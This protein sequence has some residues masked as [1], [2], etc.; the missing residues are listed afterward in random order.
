MSDLIVQDAKLVDEDSIP[1]D[2]L[3][4]IETLQSIGNKL[5]AR[6]GP[7]HLSR[8]VV[9]EINDERNKTKRTE[10][11][12][13][14]QPAQPRRY[15]TLIDS[16]KRPEE[17]ALLRRVYGSLLQV[18]CVFAPE[19]V[20]RERLGGNRFKASDVD[21][22]F[23]MDE[24]EGSD[25]GQKVRDT[26]HISDFF[27][28]NDEPND[29]TLSGSV[30]RFLEI[31]FGTHVHTPTLDETAM[32]AATA[33]ARGSACLSRQV[34]AVIYGVGGEQI[35]QGC[36]DVPK[37]GGGLYGEGDSTGDHRCFKWGGKICHNDF[38]KADRF[39]ELVEILQKEGLLLERDVG[40]ARK[41]IAAS[42]LKDLLEFS[43]AVHAEMEAII[44]VGRN[45]NTGLVGA[46]LYCTT[47]PCHSCARHIIAS[48]ISRVLYI[49]PYPKSL[50]G[51][52]HEDAI[53]F[54]A[55]STDSVVFLQYQGV[56][57]VKINELFSVRGER[58]RD[59]RLFVADPRHAEPVSVGPLDGIE[60]R[61]AL[62]IASKS[63]D[64]T[65]PME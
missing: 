37:S 28:R 5:R 61:E 48:G 3:A 63:S 9:E 57:P 64:E 49:E 22:I 34:G 39:D 47:F 11:G 46:T 17:I 29:E 38:Q 65:P 25:F 54:S 6:F 44:S 41:A 4:R 43:R 14:E 33:A 60:I 52:L 58:K 40:K 16:L 1:V 10:E 36:N 53:K 18:F 21:K 35:G 8:R 51:V 24:D 7:D 56:A 12:G 26:S 13:A 19:D 27:L 31:I 45:G 30:D 2:S 62:V 20:R 15:A 55:N 32:Y 59:G 42:R 23:E 50:A